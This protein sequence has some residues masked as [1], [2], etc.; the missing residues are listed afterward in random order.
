MCVLVVVIYHV[1]VRKVVIYQMK[2]EEQEDEPPQ[3][4]PFLQ[5]GRR[6]GTKIAMTTAAVA[7]AAAL[8]QLFSHSMRDRAETKGI[9][10]MDADSVEQ[11]PIL[12]KRLQE[13]KQFAYVKPMYFEELVNQADLLCALVDG[14]QSSAL[15]GE[16][17]IT[18][19]RKA[20]THYE[21]AVSNMDAMTGKASKSRRVPPQDA[22][23]IMG[24]CQEIR[25]LLLKEYENI[26]TL[27]SRRMS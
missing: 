2:E 11:R 3:R 10:N 19:V 8:Y 16:V 14:L 20:K 9:L 26:Y 5:M 24:L 15:R 12:S 6:Q 7:T 1:K 18:D 25:P 17:T 27:A 4:G 13:L 22:A 23:Q 21:R